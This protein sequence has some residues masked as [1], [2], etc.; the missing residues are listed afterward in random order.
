MTVSV[1]TN[2]VVFAGTGIAGPFTFPFPIMDDDDLAVIKRD[3]NWQEAW[4]VK[5]VDYT[6][7]YVTGAQSGY[8]T[9]E[10]VLS[11][12]YAL[13]LTRL[14]EQTQE[15]D[16]V[17]HE[18]F[19][20]NAT[21]TA[22]DRLECQIQDLQ[23]QVGRAIVLPR[24][25]TLSYLLY[26][27]PIPYYLIG[28]DS[29]G[30]A[31]AY[32]PPA[33]T[34]GTT[35]NYPGLTLWFGSRRI[36]SYEVIYV[37]IAGASFTLPA[38]LT[39]SQAYLEVASTAEYIISIQKNGT[40]IGTLRFVAGNTAGS[41]TF[42]TEVSFVAGDRLSFVGPEQDETASGLAVTIVPEEE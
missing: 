19:S 16:Y 36:E 27:K 39:G 20:A 24:S 9:L 14:T 32:Y 26:P 11:S 8:V 41:F 25:G 29:D 37:Y 38:S 18:P 1:S 2:R 13:C 3:A 22:L 33:G 15:T 35:I 31:I 34:G 10:D 21:E 12:A 30:D 5:D 17:E 6:V 28:W 4:L 7:S 40:E 42:S 23:E